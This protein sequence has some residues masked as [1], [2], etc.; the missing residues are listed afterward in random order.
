M[1]SMFRFESYKLY[2]SLT[3]WLL[4]IGMG[5]FF[6]PTLVEPID[7]VV[8]S[9]YSSF[10]GPATKQVFQMI[11]ADSNI[12]NDPETRIEEDDI[13]YKNEIYAQ[14]LHMKEAQIQRQ[15]RLDVL[16]S[17]TLEQKFVSSINL[18][19]IRYHDSAEIVATFV[20]QSGLLFP[21]IGLLLLSISYT[22]ERMT[23]VEQYQLTSRNGRE[24]LL[25]AKWMAA[26]TYVTIIHV[27]TYLATIL[28]VRS[29]LGP[30]D[31]SAPM[32]AMDGLAAAPYPLSIGGYVLCTF[33][34]QEL[35]FLTLA[36]AILCASLFAKQYSHA[37]IYVMVLIGLPLTYGYV[38]PDVFFPEFVQVL[39]FFFPS[40]GVLTRELFQTDLPFVL[41]M[42]VMLVW[43]VLIVTLYVFMM[44]SVKRRE[45]A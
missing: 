21:L 33:I 4:L 16:K 1:M 40:R 18:S 13:L 27:L 22:R 42:I 39:I 25:R 30:I 24:A 17:D 26:A 36:T 7:H 19:S 35:A 44:R 10:E 2:K 23:G 11:K 29:Q 43:I 45:L 5:L 37:F 20:N 15:Q 12:I 6:F 9:R 8:K 41:P 31:W 38:I 34:Y 32:Q 14:I 28:V 3:V